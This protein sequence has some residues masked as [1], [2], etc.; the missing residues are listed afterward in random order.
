MGLGGAGATLMM[1]GIPMA[2]GQPT[3]LSA[4][5]GESRSERILLIVRLQGGNDGLN[6]IV[7]IYDYDRY[8]NARPTIRHEMADIHIERKMGF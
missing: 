2:F 8:A 1:N 7:P 6:T 4:A 5:L 3:P